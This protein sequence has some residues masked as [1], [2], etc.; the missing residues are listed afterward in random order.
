M[1]GIISNQDNMD[2]TSFICK[3]T[4]KDHCPINT[5]RLKLKSR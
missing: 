5:A 2:Y 3:M 4:S 1:W